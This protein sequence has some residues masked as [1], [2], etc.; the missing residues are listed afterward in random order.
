MI[1]CSRNWVDCLVWYPYVHEQY[2]P[3]VPIMFLPDKGG[4]QE[5]LKLNTPEYQ[6]NIKLLLN[7][8]HYA[9]WKIQDGK[10]MIQRKMM[11]GDFN[12]PFKKLQN[13]P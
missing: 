8:Q 2:I 13:V 12:L 9:K 6:K 11:F 10:I 4:I 5:A 1:S 3:Y 7:D